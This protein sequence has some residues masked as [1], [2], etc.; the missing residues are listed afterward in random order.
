[1]SDHDRLIDELARAGAPVRRVAPA[2]LRAA[3]WVPLALALGGMAAL[4]LVHRDA[5]DWSA[6]NAALAMANVALSLAIGAAGLMAALSVSV[7]GGGIR[8]KGLIAALLLAWIAVAAAGIGSF[9]A[10]G[11][12]AHHRTPCFIFVVTVGLP[13]V[14]VAV[15]ALRRTRSL[16]PVRSL[17]L[18]G[19]GAA[20]LAF[21]LLALC[22]PVELYAVD[23]L[24]HIAGALVLG[25]VAVL[26]GR[27]AIAA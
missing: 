25:G 1:M 22:H 18:A 14:A 10:P 21:A 11:A 2:W 5:T 24:M 20:F 19:G 17:A 27:R 12:V 15:L 16:T 8:G 4:W 7:A 3:G 23:F 9:A 6:P 13:M 26:L